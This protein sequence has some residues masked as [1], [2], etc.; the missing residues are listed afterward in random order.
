MCIYNISYVRMAKIFNLKMHRLLYITKSLPGTLYDGIGCLYYMCIH[1]HFV[2]FCHRIFK[3]S[4]NVT[5]IWPIKFCHRKSPC[6]NPFS[7]LYVLAPE[8]GL[9]CRQGVKAQLKLNFSH[10][11]CYVTSNKIGPRYLNLSP[12]P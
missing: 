8:D 12:C 9:R 3:M 5:D 6:H 11:G 4:Q 10:Y 1:C 7:G 2:T